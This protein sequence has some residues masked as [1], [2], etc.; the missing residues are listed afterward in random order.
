MRSGTT[1]SLETK[2]LPSESFEQ[3]RFGNSVSIS[4]NLIV[5]GA[6]LHDFPFSG[7]GAAYIF[8]REDSG[9]VEETKLTALDGAVSDAFGSS[10]AI[11]NDRVLVGALGANVGGAAY[12]FERSGMSWIQTVKYFPTSPNNEQHFGIFVAISGGVGMVGAAKDN[13]TVSVFGEAYI[14]A[15][16]DADCNGNGNLDACDIQLG[17]STDCPTNGIPDECERDPNTEPDCNG[18][19]ETDAC[20][21]QAGTSFDCNEQRSS[22]RV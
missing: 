6:L 13:S 15:I 14:L 10:V 12:L 17:N 22:R 9:W 11:E 1:W 18:N 3:D 21:I 2:L 4:G 8:R 20:D 5:V 19:G 7:E 16:T